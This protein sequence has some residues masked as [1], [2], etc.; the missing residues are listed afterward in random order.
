MGLHLAGCVNGAGMVDWG[1]SDRPEE[2]KVLAVR[3]L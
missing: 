2:S 3:V 1:R